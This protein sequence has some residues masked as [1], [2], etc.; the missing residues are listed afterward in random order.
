MRRLDEDVFRNG[1]VYREMTIQRG[2]SEGTRSRR[3]QSFAVVVVVA[4][5]GR[6]GG[7]DRQHEQAGDQMG[8]R[9]AHD[10]YARTPPEPSGQF[11]AWL[12]PAARASEHQDRRQ[13]GHRGQES[14][15]DP[16]RRR[17]SDRFEHTH[18]GEADEQKSNAHGGGGR[19]DD[20]SD[21]DQCPLEC[22]IESLT[23]PQVVVIAADEKDRVIRAGAGHDR[24]QKDDGLVRDTR[25][26]QL[27]VAGH[28]RLCDHQGQPDR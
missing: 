22:L 1:L 7:Q 5:E 23:R 20:L 24:A 11:A 17:H 9:P 21:R 3:T 28:H 14:H 27:G 16:D 6:A 25:A 13:Q 2:I 15:A 18:S 26:G 8:L 19:R 12:D 4:H 10:A